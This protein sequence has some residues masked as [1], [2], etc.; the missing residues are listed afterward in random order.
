MSQPLRCHEPATAD[1]GQLYQKLVEELTDFVVFLIDPD[2]CIVS[3]NPGV[4]RVLGYTEV[5]W[6]GQ[7]AEMIFTAEDR[8]QDQSQLE[9]EHSAREGCTRDVRWH[10]RKNGEHLFVEGSLVAL[11]DSET[12]QLLG[13]SKVM[14]DVTDRKKRELALQDALAYAESI[15][16]T[17]REP[18]LVMDGQLRVRSANRSFY[19]TFRVSPED[20]QGKLLY[21]LG[22]SQWDIPRLRE[23]LEE[24]LP[25]NKT[26]EGFEVEGSFPGIGL[27]VMLLN[28]RKLWRE[29]NHTEL[30]LLAIEDVTDSHEAATRETALLELGDGLRLLQ[31]PSEMGR[32]AAGIVGRILG[33][34]RGGYGTIDADQETV[35]IE[36]DWAK[37][38]AP[39]ARGIFQIS[40]YGI[41]IALALKQGE[42]T[43]I[44]N[45]ASDPRTANQVANFEALEIRALLNAP[46][47]EKGRLV[48]VLYLHD[49]APRDWSEETI[50]FVRA[51]L[52]RTWTA[53][54]RARTEMERE[55]LL[56]EIRRSNSELT[57]F[58]HVVS[59]DLQTPIRGIESF[60]ELLLRRS[61][62]Q[63]DSTAQEY[64]ELIRDSADSM[65]LLVKTLLGYAT[66]GNG[67]LTRT[68]VALDAILDTVLNSLRTSIVEAGAAIEV[69]PL[70]TVPGDP[71]LLQQLLQNLLSN[72]LKYRKPEQKLK[73]KVNAEAQFDAWVVCVA[74]NGE[75]IDPLYHSQ[76]FAPLKRLHGM[77]VEGTGIGLAVCKR[78]VEHHGGRIW[79]ESE[80]G[81]GATFHFTLPKHL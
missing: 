7:A 34:A 51:V 8:A 47:L 74:D 77:E 6:V 66:V 24:V 4:E 78:I 71:V 42:I 68:P 49:S 44:S 38:T 9:M 59:H 60:S 53:T 27:R 67:A 41:G 5:E 76:I 75:G 33:V 46:L 63:L 58:A 65:H 80:A 56:S 12:G 55:R 1:Y 36:W 17:V 32:L 13:Y 18:M 14:R 30:I 21:K 37:G 79:V 45:V 3:W 81:E 50:S 35:T 23:S 64:L 62:G 25:E 28:A 29:G 43:A 40:D 31:T 61:Q 2:G 26:V 52:D 72:A 10:Q 11:R 57:E 39:P 15:V 20:T 48:A 22:D 19:R 70:P 54:E 16:D 73:I 69:G